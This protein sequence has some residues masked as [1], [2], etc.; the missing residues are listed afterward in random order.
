MEARRH[1]E[2]EGLKY[3][4]SG[5]IPDSAM[6]RVKLAVLTKVVRKAFMTRVFRGSVSPWQEEF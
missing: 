3:V 1:G 2:N 6:R 4:D 5:R